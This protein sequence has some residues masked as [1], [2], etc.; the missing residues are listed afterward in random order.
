MI[1]STKC[2]VRSLARLAAISLTV[3]I[4]SPPAHCT[5]IA[6]KISFPDPPSISSAASSPD[7]ALLVSVFLDASGPQQANWIFGN[8]TLPLNLSG[9]DKITRLCFFKNPK[10]DTDQAHLWVETFLGDSPTPLKSVS[11]AKTSDCTF[12][13]WITQIE[14]RIL[15]LS[16]MNLSFENEIPPPGTPLINQ[17]GKIV[18]LLLQ[19][20]SQN[21][22]YAIPA[23]AVHRVQRD[24]STQE[25]LIKGWVGIT[26]SPS[27]Q[28]PR[29]ISVTPNSPA[30]K[31][32]IIPNDILVKIGPHPIARYP[33]AVN[34]LFYTI[35]DIVTPIQILR[36]NRLIELS[37]TPIA[38]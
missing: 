30:A 27:S 1:G 15:P 9:H 4:S 13:K 25:N 23:Q 37:V 36:N 33:D 8:Q 11:Y 14:D 2:S 20:A 22:A 17:Q 6:F 19:S 31:A 10:P 26:L 18:A 29:I 12:Q 34:A 24:F 7:P 16:L 28:A 38:K 21:S 35:P 5:P 32:G 3:I